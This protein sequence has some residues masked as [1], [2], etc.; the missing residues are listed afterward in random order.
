MNNFVVEGETMQ[1][2]LER[3]KNNP[4]QFDIAWKLMRT[5]I[6][7]REWEEIEIM[8]LIKGMVEN[9]NRG[10]VDAKAS[11]ET[12]IRIIDDYCITKEN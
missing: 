11:V 1:E 7:A 8:Q 10:L 5:E 6:E 12:I 2:H 4:G 3:V 9:W